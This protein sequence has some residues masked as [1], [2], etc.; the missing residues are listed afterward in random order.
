MSPTAS[1]NALPTV[2]PNCSGWPWTEHWTCRPEPV[3][4][5][6]VLP[7]I[8]VVTPCLNSA[9]YVEA[10]LRSVLLQHYP[11]LQYLVLDGGSTDGS[12]DILRRYQY[13]LEYFVSEPDAGQYDAIQKGF[14]RSTGEIMLWLNSD[15]MLAPGCLWRLA[16]VFGSFRQVEWVSGIPFYWS[17][18]AS[19]IEIMAQLPY[20]RDLMRLGGYEGRALHWVMQECT[21]WRRS[22]W[23]R[24]GGT[25][26]TCWDFAGDFELWLRFASRAQL[27]TV[28]AFFGGNRQH[29]G[30]KTR[31]QERYF[32]EVDDVLRL[33]AAA[34]IGNRAMRLPALRKVLRAWLMLRRW[35]NHIFWDAGEQRWRT[36]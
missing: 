17:R 26:A 5:F 35:R 11:R 15:D 24:A 23:E 16:T 36:Q 4:K 9:G 29:P 14:E 20:Q 6:D 13:F 32:R 7:T 25:L 21:A 22:L 12:I 33:H 1:R 2:P 28:A 3:S 18:D 10:A 31:D 19:D 30:Q 27:Y 8:S 34:R